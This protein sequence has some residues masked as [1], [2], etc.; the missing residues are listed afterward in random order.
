MDNKKERSLQNIVVVGG[1]TAGWITALYA[2]VALP[3]SNVTVV[4]SD[5]IGIL[6]AGEGATPQLINALDHLGIPVSFLISKAGATIKS[7]IKFTNWK[8]D[9]THYY[10]SF[11]VLDSN[12]GLEGLGVDPYRTSLPPSFVTNIVRDEDVNVIDYISKVCES[13]KVPFQVRNYPDLNP[14][15]NIFRFHS[16]ALFSLHFDARKLAQTLKEIAID[17]GINRVE[18]VVESTI[19]DKNGE[20]TQLV[21]KNSNDK[22]D[23][24][25]LF[26][27]TG[28]ARVFSLKKYNSP[29]HSHSS[30]L[31]VDTA[32]PFFLPHENDKIP[33]YTESI[34]MKYGWM[35]KI[36]TQERF[37]CGYVFDSSLVTAEDAIKEIEELVGHPI[38]SPKTFKFSAGYLTQPWSNN[39]IA[40]GLSSGFIEPLEATSIWVTIMSLQYIFAN[41]EVLSSTDVRH[42]EHFNSRFSDVNDQVVDFVYFHYM[43]GRDDTEFWKKFNNLDNA[44]EQV[45]KI[46]KA[47][48]YRLPQYDDHLGKLF[49]LLSWLSVGRGID[50]LN[51]EL[52]QKAHNQSPALQTLSLGYN[53]LKSRQDFAALHAIDHKHFIEQVNNEV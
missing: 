38:Q 16:T 28:F 43:S 6:G 20:I 24:D 52:F 11:H 46:I 33:S 14:Y 21:L 25:F 9:G 17:R 15:N 48:D 29:W 3:N 30:K 37:G 7:G 34:A 40:I 42:S 2:K 51:V 45:K 12:L 39:C 44:P 53:S 18:G 10:H 50:R 5:D 31:P 27:C 47:W 26:D 32:I 36:P 8:N 49:T 13:G 22:V 19:D 41:V 4:E 23:V 35:W 1:G